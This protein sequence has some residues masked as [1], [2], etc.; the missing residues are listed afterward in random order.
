MPLFIKQQ[1]KGTKI[2]TEDQTQQTNT[3]EC[4]RDIDRAVSFTQ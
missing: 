1:A 4:K 2:D 3:N